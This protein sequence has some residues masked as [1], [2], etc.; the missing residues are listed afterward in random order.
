MTEELLLLLLSAAGAL[1]SYQYG[2]SSPWL[3]KEVA[4]AI[5]RVLGITEEQQEEEQHENRVCT[6]DQ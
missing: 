1:R 4:D 5:D 3:A 2:N 6:S